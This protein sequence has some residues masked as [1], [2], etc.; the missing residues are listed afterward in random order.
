MIHTF[1]MVLAMALL[2]RAHLDGLP[3]EH[4]VYYLV[5]F[6]LSAGGAALSYRFFE[7]PLLR[8]KDRYFAGAR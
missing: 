7:T 1:L 8:L 6:A 5:A 2:Q 4:L 3:A